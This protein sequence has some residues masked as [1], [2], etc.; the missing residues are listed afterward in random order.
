M[1][2]F[3]YVVDDTVLSLYVLNLEELKI[4]I[5]WFLSFSFFLKS[6]L[7]LPR[8]VAGTFNHSA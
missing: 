4:F 5:L 3:S 8:V 6:G 7:M 1:E 2:K